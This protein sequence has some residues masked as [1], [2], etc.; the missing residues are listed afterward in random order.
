M[1]A[2]AVL[3]VS[4]GAGTAAA[5][6]SRDEPA[7]P[8]AAALAPPGEAPAPTATGA[9]PGKW[10][11][12][13]ADADLDAPDGEHRLAAG[14][15]P[16]AITVCRQET[17]RRADGGLDLVA[18][19]LRGEDTAALVAAL[20]LP[21]L[22]PNGGACRAMLKRGVGWFALHDA[23]G[24]WVRPGTPL[25]GCGNTRQEVVDAYAALRLTRVSASVVR[26]LESA[27]AAA[28]GCAQDWKNMV[29]VEAPTARPGPG[30]DVRGDEIRVCVYRVGPDHGEFVE[31]E[32]L[33][34]GERR[35][36]I[37]RAL[38]AAGPAGACAKGASRFA[39]LR[40]T[41]TNGDEVYVELD[42]C[43]RILLP[44]RVLAQAD[45]PLIQLIEES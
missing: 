17:R 40:P 34:A 23:D 7:P 43:R 21:D 29:A 11:S 12:C 18:V 9:A 16:V 15:S 1:V 38:A 5:L 35:T 3:V 33:R 22:A 44:G 32:L 30:A 26:E 42:G 28:S 10:V 27:G 19:E 25:D 13:A 36:A 6:A 8:P 24:R 31:G 39:V 14:F 45:P 4:L 37:G 20:R 41:K 2:G